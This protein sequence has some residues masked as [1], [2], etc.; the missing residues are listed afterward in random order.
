MESL[1]T[2]IP[3]ALC[4]VLGAVMFISRNPRML[5]SYHYATTPPEKLPKLARAEGAGMIGLGIGVALMGFAS[6]A[7]GAPGIAATIAG[8]VLFVACIAEMLIM[9]VY[10]NGGLM[11]FS[12]QIAPGPFATMRPMKRVAVCALVGAACSLL[13]IVPG[14][15]MIATGDV[16]PLHSYH[17][18]NVA[19]ADLPRLATAEGACMIVLGVAIFL[20][21]L[22][23]AGM[24]GKRPFPRWSIVLMAAGVACLC[25]GLIGLLGFI[26][27]FNGS[28]MGSATL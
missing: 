13:G 26:I 12:G 25:I 2:L 10:Y 24:L 11:T 4:I 15:H 14:I 5:H 18:A 3:A 28:L 27:Y 9:I 7:P 8:T 21:M 22:A 19:A 1:V 23:G 16:S 20:C 6:N 17:Y